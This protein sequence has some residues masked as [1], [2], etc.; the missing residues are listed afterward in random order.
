M[1]EAAMDRIIERVIAWAQPRPDIRAAFVAGSRARANHPADDWSDLDVVIVADDPQPYLASAEWLSAIGE[2]RLTFLEPTAVGGLTERRALFDGGLDVDITFV[3]TEFVQHML[4]HAIPAEVAQVFQQGVRILFDKDA[5]IAGLVHAPHS[6]VP[7]LNPP[8]AAGF[9]EL[10]NDFLYHAIW[11]AKKLRRG[12]VFVAKAS[13]DIHMKWLLLRLIEWHAQASHGPAY[14]TWHAGRFLEQWADPRIIADLR[15][16]YAQY[17]AADV[18]RALY[19]SLRAFHWI[20]LEI[21]DRLQYEYPHQSHSY[22]EVWL[23]TQLP[24]ELQP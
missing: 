15:G 3:P 16:T 1:I 2:V 11:S 19:A 23:Q 22:V 7:R 14:Q 20:A 17:D 13:C 4:Q 9:G 12:E 5:T 18:R 8:T 21:A 6:E 24:E 10:V